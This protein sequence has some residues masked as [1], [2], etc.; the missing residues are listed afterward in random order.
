MTLREDPAVPPEMGVS[1]VIPSHQRS[2]YLRDALHD[3]DRQDLPTKE[4]LVV[5]QT[6]PS[7]AELEE[8]LQAFKGPL[9]I[10]LLDER[11]ASLARNVGL[12]EARHD[13]VLFLDD[14]V[15][16]ENPGFLRR[17]AGNFDDA[18]LS[19]VYGQVLEPGQRPDPPTGP[20][21]N[22]KALL[23]VPPTHARRCRVRDSASNNLS[24]RRQWA[25]VAGGMDA[26]FERGAR[27]EEAEFNLRYTKRFGPLIFDPEATLVHLSAGGGSRTWGHVRRFVPMHHIVGHWYF[28]LASIRDR[29]QSPREIA[30]ELRHIATALL[31][32]PRA[33]WN[34]LGHARN[35]GRA[36][37]GFGIAAWRLRR[38][39]RRIEELDGASYRL[40]AE[41][42]HSRVAAH[43][44]HSVGS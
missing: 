5:L 38:G 27:R 34:P 28:L 14:D 17:H 18:V 10:F 13:I 19:G 39:H 44:D 30:G 37:W 21:D 22:G 1:V 26:N 3:L 8:L 6:Q 12:R 16:I 29:T 43:S 24:I 20:D 40:L 42:G 25:M 15:R 2:T 36:V 9:R 7:E 35:L 32:N 31:R 11:N 33:G 4:C 23:R 41:R